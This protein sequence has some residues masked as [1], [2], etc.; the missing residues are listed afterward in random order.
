[1]CQ[2]LPCV[3]HR[4]A[5]ISNRLE[6]GVQL[7]GGLVGIVRQE[8]LLER[9]VTVFFPT[10]RQEFRLREVDLRSAE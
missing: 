1:M 8:H 4:V 3:G 7:P 5:L 6:K 2:G 9:E 10:L